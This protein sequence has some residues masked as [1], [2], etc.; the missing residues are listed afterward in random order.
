MIFM[1]C[2]MQTSFTSCTFTT[3]C[4][5][6]LSDG[7]LASWTI[8]IILSTLSTFSRG[9]PLSCPTLC[10]SRSIFS[11]SLNEVGDTPGEKEDTSGHGY[12][13]EGGNLG[14][15]SEIC[16]G[17][18]KQSFTLQLHVTSS[19]ARLQILSCS[20][21]FSTG[22]QLRDEIWEWPGNETK[23]YHS[24][25]QVFTFLGFK[26]ISYQINLTA[27]QLHPVVLK[28]FVSCLQI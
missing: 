25:N 26:I 14:S 21:F 11:Q 22:P 16:I 8:S 5:S 13:V 12:M 24:V 2:A 23:W 6:Q 17:S 3:I 10:S 28:G 4:N 1:T 15:V 19:P 9:L 7:H 27:F 20:G 18:R